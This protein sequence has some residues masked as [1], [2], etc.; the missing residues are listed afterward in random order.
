MCTHHV[1]TNSRGSC[2]RLEC[3]GSGGVGLGECLDG[4]R[5][6]HTR[7]QAL[8]AR[9]PHRVSVCIHTASSASRYGKPNLQLCVLARGCVGLSV[10]VYLWPHLIA[11][12][13]DG[14]LIGNQVLCHT[15]QLHRSTACSTR[16]DTHTAAAQIAHDAN[17]ARGPRW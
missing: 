11:W 14:A 8:S 10:G 16:S 12:C 1:C 6:T 4:L 9:K 3:R 5:D 17:V 2:P 15:R 7:T 13:E